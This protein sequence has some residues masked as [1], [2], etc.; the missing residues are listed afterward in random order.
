MKNVSLILIILALLLAA[1]STN[2]KV[3]SPPQATSKPTH[4]SMYFYMAASLQFWDGYYN[5]AWPLFQRALNY[6]ANSSQIKRDMLLSAMY[7][8]LQQESDEGGKIKSMVDANKDLIQK[9]AELLD[10]AYSFYSSLADPSSQRWAIDAML[11]YH[12]G[13]RAHILNFLYSYSVLGLP[14]ASLL[15]PA[16]DYIQNDAQQLYYLGNLFEPL[17]PSFAFSTAKRLYE[18]DPTADSARH[19]ARLYLEL[20]AS[21]N[22]TAF[23]DGLSYPQDQQLMYHI[24]DGALSYEMLDFLNKVACK[25]IATKDSELSYIVALTALMQRNAKVFTCLETNFLQD[26]SEESGYMASL[27]IDNSFLQKDGKELA[28]LLDSISNSS[29]LENIIRFYLLGFSNALKDEEQ[30]PSDSVFIDFAN[31]LKQS[32]PAGIK[33]DYLVI[34]TLAIPD[35]DT[36]SEETY[37]QTKESLILS[38]IQQ[39]H[40]NSDDFSWLLQRYYFTERMQERIPLLRLAIQSF[41]DQAVWYN[42]LGYTMLTL[43]GDLDEAGELIFKALSMDPQNYFYLDSIAWYFYL[44][45]DYQQALNYISPVM[46]MADMPA[47]IAYHIGLIHMRLSDFENARAYMKYASQFTDE[48]PEYAQKAKRALELWGK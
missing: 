37:K 7:H 5:N 8:Y 20:E 16:L 32:L 45:K 47:E 44:K 29:E 11:K 17:D 35:D 36:N 19:L 30:T 14:D 41:P 25:V 6:D 43:G 28:P 18:I 1:C 22:D 33:R 31:M 21:E 46:D 9:D 12:P 2:I 40:Y 42:D 48:E 24:L 38:F 10:A 26:S 3:G 34:T 15:Y 27:L 13:A 23:F 4:N 39:E